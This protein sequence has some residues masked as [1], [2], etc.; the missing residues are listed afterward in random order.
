M[1]LAFMAAGAEYLA[2]EW[3]I[4][5]GDGQA[6]YGLPSI[7]QIWSWHLRYL[8][9]YWARLDR[10]QRN[11]LRILRLYQRLYR[12][13]TAKR[14]PAGFPFDV[15]HRLSIEGG[16][17]GIGQVRSPPERLFDEEVSYSPASIERLFFATSSEGPT[18]ARAIEGIEVARRMVASLSW[19]RR[20]LMA[21]Y[22]QF[23]FAFPNRRNSWLE[24]VEVHEL[25]L[26]SQAFAS[27]GA[28]EV[29]HPYPVALDELLRAAAP[30]YD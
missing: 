22:Q 1:L 2:D 14:E 4:V 6:L 27:K 7:L 28:Y 17:S 21:A 30:L 19:E 13:I 9:K 29:S 24:D 18:T 11:R 10:R 12:L 16:N 8:P 26:L 3:A 15:L 23:K 5:S 20:H 25:D